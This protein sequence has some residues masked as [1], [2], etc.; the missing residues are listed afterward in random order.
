MTQ[1]IERQLA[2]Y[3]TALR[4][5]AQAV[6][7]DEV[8][9]RTLPRRHL[10]RPGRAV[11]AGA[12]LV[13]VSIGALFL[14]L[15]M[16]QFIGAGPALRSVAGRSGRVTGPGI[17][18]LTAG[19]GAAALIALTVG[20]GLRRSRIAR[21]TRAS[22]ARERRKKKMQT[23][24]KSIAPV[25]RLERN[26]K[27]LVIAL[28]VTTLLA[29]GFAAWLAL[30]NVRLGAEGDIVNLMKDYDAAWDAADGAAVVAL[31]TKDAT[32]LA[33]NGMSY[34]VDV[35][36]SLIGDIG[37]FSTTQI[38]DY[39]IMPK[40]DHWFVATADE[41]TMGDRVYNEMA[42]F[43]VVEQQGEYLIEYHETWQVP[44]S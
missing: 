2:S 20:L 34:G 44:S 33:G 1:S 27:Y 43:K 19:G 29:A 26:N 13:L 4:R 28:V 36:E 24:E 41:I 37:S 42:I 16:L 17:V 35:L 18:A 14:G 39:V 3:G 11:V 15:L 32:V 38:D 21:A 9:S 40:S 30:D 31:M 12:S 23:I 5:R 22:R 25:E 10:Y 7:M 6:D 8:R